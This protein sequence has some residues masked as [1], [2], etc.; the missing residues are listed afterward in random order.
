MSMPDALPLA[1]AAALGGLVLGLAY[2]AAL[3]VSVCRYA[4]GGR[5]RALPLHLARLIAA[6]AG[7]WLLAL[8]GGAALL[9]GLLGVLLARQIA[10][11]AVRSGRW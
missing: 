7:F 1:A 2:F 10:F 11:G 8:L 6:G 9:G 3:W 5:Q 4:T